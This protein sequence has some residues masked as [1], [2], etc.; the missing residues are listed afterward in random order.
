MELVSS[1]SAENAWNIATALL[2]I[3]VYCV[4][5]QYWGCLNSIRQGQSA[6]K[7]THEQQQSSSST[8]APLITK[9]ERKVTILSPL[10]HPATDTTEVSEET[11]VSES[12][13]D[14]YQVEE[15]F[16]T[17]PSL[18]TISKSSKPVRVIGGKPIRLPD[19][20]ES[21]C[22][23][24]NSALKLKRKLMRHDIA[25]HASLSGSINSTGS[26]KQQG[27]RRSHTGF[28]VPPKAPK[29]G[30]IR[31]YSSLDHPAADGNL[32]RDVLLLNRLSQEQTKQ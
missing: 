7:Q 13:D 24:L 20:P 11:E 22:P 23:A 14:H 6:S 15:V 31:R 25:C 16:Q 9:P 3:A 29:P 1:F 32:K 17:P 5:V 12:Y 4:P 2:I 26:G 19:I 28:T 18:K 10:P 30:P 27:H 8:A 21:P